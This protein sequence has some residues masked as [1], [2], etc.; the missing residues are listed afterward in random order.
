MVSEGLDEE[1]EDVALI[2]AVGPTHVTADDRLDLVL[3]H[4]LANE[5]E[6][7]SGVGCGETARNR[8]PE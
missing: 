3:V 6:E 7:L 1:V 5:R 2:G 8:S 4:D